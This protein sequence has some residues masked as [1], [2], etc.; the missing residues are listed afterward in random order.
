VH[1]LPRG[2]RFAVPR[3]RFV[4]DGTRRLRGGRRPG[5]LERRAAGRECPCTSPMTNGKENRENSLPR[6]ATVST[7]RGRLDDHALRHEARLSPPAWTD[8]QARAAPSEL[9][10]AS[11]VRQLARDEPS[12]P[13][14]AG[15]WF[16]RMRRKS[17]V[18]WSVSQDR[19]TKRRGLRPARCHAALLVLSR[20]LRA[21]LAVACGQPGQRTAPRQPPHMPFF[22]PKNGD[23]SD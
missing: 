10:G 5:N 7:L 14:A 18:P 2:S 11:S 20:P 13:G 17:P 3:E 21:A 9:L 4:G 19:T 12:W 6:S 22:F 8:R 15:A 23:F 1:E 16:W